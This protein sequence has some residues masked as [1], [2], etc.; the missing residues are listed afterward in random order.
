MSQLFSLLKNKR[1]K[2]LLEV[3]IHSNKTNGK[4]VEFTELYILGILTRL[5][6]GLDNWV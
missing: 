1:G 3:E 5:I 4:N 2:K 6:E